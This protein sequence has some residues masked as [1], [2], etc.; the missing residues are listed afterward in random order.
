MFEDPVA[1]ANFRE[2]LNDAVCADL[3]IRTDLYVVFNN[4]I[5]IDYSVAGDRDTCADYGCGM[6]GHSR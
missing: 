3:A 1:G 5:S 2:S 6:N 4:D